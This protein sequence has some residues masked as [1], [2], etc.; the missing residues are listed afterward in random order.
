MS[1]K[2]ADKILDHRLQGVGDPQAPFGPCAIVVDR[3]RSQFPEEFHND[4]IGLKREPGG[5]D[6]FPDDLDQFKRRKCR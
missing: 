4:W 6:S 2:F 3:E 1:F 5:R